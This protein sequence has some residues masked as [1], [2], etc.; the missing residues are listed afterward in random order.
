VGAF[1]NT[2]SVSLVL[3]RRYGLHRPA[4]RRKHACQGVTGAVDYGSVSLRNKTEQAAVKLTVHHFSGPAAKALM[5]AASNPAVKFA[6]PAVPATA[7]APSWPATPIGDLLLSRTGQ[8][9]ETLSLFPGLARSLPPGHEWTALQGLR[10]MEQAVENA[11]GKDAFGAGVFVLGAG[12]QLA[13]MADCSLPLATRLAAGGKLAAGGVGAAA[14]FVPALAPSAGILRDVFLV[15]TMPAAIGTALDADA[16]AF[17][18]L[19][20][21]GKALATG[22]MAVSHAIPGLAPYQAAFGNLA[23]LCSVGD[24]VYGVVVEPIA[25]ENPR[26]GK[27]PSA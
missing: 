12:S 18:R 20:A 15:A 25:G 5:P 22:A 7:P 14:P 8:K 23:W 26:V 17:R 11:V 21:A 16:P 24:E 19:T 13:K 2:D 3:N 6:L 4:R 1:S 9:P 27:Q 10:A